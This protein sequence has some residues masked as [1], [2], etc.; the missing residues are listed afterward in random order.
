MTFLDVYEFWKTDDFFGLNTRKELDALDPVA[1]AK[2][3]ED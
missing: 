2:E 3:I 1:D